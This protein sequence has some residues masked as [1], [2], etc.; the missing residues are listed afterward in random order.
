MPGSALIFGFMACDLLWV[1][2]ATKLKTVTYDTE[3]CIGFDLNGTAVSAMTL[4]HYFLQTG[5]KGD[6]G[7]NLYLVC[8]RITS[9]TPLTQVDEGHIPTEFDL[10]I[11]A[12]SVCFSIIYLFN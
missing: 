7:R 11:E 1:V 2:N 6:I 9:T 3:I 5:E 8:S 10:K 4:L 12:F